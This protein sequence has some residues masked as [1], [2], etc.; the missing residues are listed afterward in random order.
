MAEYAKRFDI[1]GVVVTFGNTY[2]D[3]EILA[4]NRL[5]RGA[6]VRAVWCNAPPPSVAWKKDDPPNPRGGTPRRLSPALP[7]YFSPPA[8]TLCRPRP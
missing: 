4:A 5:P 6:A 2:R 1:R 8:A 7:W 3:P